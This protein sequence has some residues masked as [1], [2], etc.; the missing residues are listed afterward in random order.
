M[1]STENKSWCP[2]LNTIKEIADTYFTWYGNYGNYIF[3]EWVNILKITKERADLLKIIEPLQINQY[4][5]LILIRFGLAEMQD[6]GG[7]MWSNENSIYRECRSVVIDIREFEV[8]QAPFRKFFNLNEVEENSIENIVIEINNAKSVEFTNKLDGSMQCA[9]MY[10]DK[11][12]LTGSMAISPKTSWRLEEGY[13]MLTE[14]HKK[15]IR[16][17]PNLTFIFEYISLKDPHVVLYTKDKQGMYLIGVR[18]KI[19]GKQFS[20]EG[21]KGFSIIYD[22]PMTEIEDITLDKALEM[23]KT[24]ESCDKEGWVLNIDG[25]MVK[26][27]CD[28]YVKLHKCLDKVSSVNVIIQSIADGTYDDLISKIPSGY[29]ARVEGVSK[30][31]FNYVATMNSEINLYYN[32]MKHIE[33]EKEAMKYITFEVPTIFQEHVRNLYRGRDFNVLKTKTR[34]KRL[35]ELGIA[36]NISNLFEEE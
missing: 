25:H 4:E 1:E 32:T 13:K 11:I 34:Y 15:M 26:V 29:R 6:Q 36:D 10:K 33:D 2:I 5:D 12:L 16:D 24:L 19:N 9:T 3:D 7:E 8:V 21:I 23:S 27:K 31:I 35:N 28:D 20:Y 18:N 17:N 30:K 14:N 22:I